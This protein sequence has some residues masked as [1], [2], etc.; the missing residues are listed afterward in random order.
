M[1]RNRGNF[2][3]WEYQDFI[4]QEWQPDH[5]WA[6]LGGNN[7]RS[8]AYARSFLWDTVKENVNHELCRWLGEGWEPVDEIGSHALSIRAAETVGPRVDGSDVALWLLTGGVAL[9]M[10]LVLGTPPRVYAIYRPA[11][12]RVQVRRLKVSE[13]EAA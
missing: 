6:T 4:Y 1:A 3:N 9:L 10:R 5:V 2:S 12:F 8:A 11:E 7:P 13:S